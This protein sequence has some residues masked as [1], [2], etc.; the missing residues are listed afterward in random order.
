MTIRLALNPTIP[1]IPTLLLSGAIPISVQS[2][3]PFSCRL[4]IEIP[5]SY[6]L[7]APHMSVSFRDSNSSKAGQGPDRKL[8]IRPNQYVNENGKVQHPYLMQWRQHWD[9]CYTSLLFPSISIIVA[10]FYALSF[11]VR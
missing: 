11:A 4:Q 8:D 5:Q 9:V 3:M 1:D 2:I 6:P 10:I 7:E